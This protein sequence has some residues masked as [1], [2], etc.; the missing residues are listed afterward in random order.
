MTDARGGLVRFTQ[1]RRNYVS[2][3]VFEFLEDGDLWLPERTY[4]VRGA[5]HQQPGD[6]IPFAYSIVTILSTGER[7]EALETV[8]ATLTRQETALEQTRTFERQ[9]DG[10]VE[11]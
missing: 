8:D 5:S 9:T 1:L 6:E 10:T 2:D 3:G 11:P 4:S 7:I